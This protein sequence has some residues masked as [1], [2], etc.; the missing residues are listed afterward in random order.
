VG[1]QVNELLVDAPRGGARRFKEPFPVL[2][3]RAEVNKAVPK[4]ERLTL[5]L[6]PTDGPAAGEGAAKQRA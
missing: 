1:E 3:V 2:A 4:I 5:A 6:P